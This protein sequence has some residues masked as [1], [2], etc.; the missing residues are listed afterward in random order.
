MIRCDDYAARYPGWYDWR[1]QMANPE[2]YGAGAPQGDD[3]EAR[4]ETGT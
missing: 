3:V 2:G 4:A 1:W